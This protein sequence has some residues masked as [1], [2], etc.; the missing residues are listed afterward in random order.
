MRGSM[1]SLFIS[2]QSVAPLK[3]HQ[4]SP[5]TASASTFDTDFLLPCAALPGADVR[6]V[7]FADVQTVLRPNQ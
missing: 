5:D 6:D 1:V 2:R 3:S 7:A 4:V